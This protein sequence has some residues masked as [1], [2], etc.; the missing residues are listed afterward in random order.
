[1]FGQ[2]LTN[3]ECGDSRTVAIYHSSDTAVPTR[4]LLTAEKLVRRFSTNHRS[5]W[6]NIVDLVPSCTRSIWTNGVF[7]AKAP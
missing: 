7:M 5:L 3:A 6:A 2:V 4:R 1:M